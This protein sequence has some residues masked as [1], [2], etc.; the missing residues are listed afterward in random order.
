MTS[1]TNTCNGNRPTWAH[2]EGAELDHLAAFIFDQR[3]GGLSESTIRQ[4]G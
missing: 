1:V 4:Y 2:L 3:L